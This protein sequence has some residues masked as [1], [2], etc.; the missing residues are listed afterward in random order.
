MPPSLNFS[1]LDFVKPSSGFHPVTWERVTLLGSQHIGG[2]RACRSSEMGTRKNDKHQ[3]LTRTY[4]NQTS[5]LMH[6]LG[7]F[8]VR[9]SHGQPQTHKTHHGPDLREAT[10]FPLIVYSVPGH[11]TNTQMTFCLGTPKWVSQTS[12]SLDSCGFGGPINFSSKLQLKWGLKESFSPCQELFNGM[13]H[14]TCT[15]GNQGNFQLL[16]VG[17][18]TSNLIHEP[19]FGHNL[20]VKCPNGSCEPI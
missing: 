15:Q 6:S 9:M 18:Q 14:T 12:Q 20:C 5:W 19:S 16:V 13:S 2:R 4:T 17:S 1:Q 11:G 3:L 7:T 10:T 8:G